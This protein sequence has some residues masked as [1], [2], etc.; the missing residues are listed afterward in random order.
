MEKKKD[1][2]RHKRFTSTGI[3]RVSLSFTA[4]FSKIIIYVAFALLFGFYCLWCRFNAAAFSIKLSLHFPSC[5][6][7]FLSLLFV[8]VLHFCTVYTL[9]I[10]VL[11]YFKTQR[12]HR[13]PADWSNRKKNRKNLFNLNLNTAQAHQRTSEFVDW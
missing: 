7:F 13:R 9:F 1:T 8:V 12:H 11:S 6:L 5:I 3:W 10:I 4:V 2:L